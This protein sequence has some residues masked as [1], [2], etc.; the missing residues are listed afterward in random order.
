M[1]VRKIFKW[2]LP[3]CLVL[4]FFAMCPAQAAN[5]TDQIIAPVD[6]SLN[7]NPLKADEKAQIINVAQVEA[8]AA[9]HYCVGYCHKH[10]EERLIECSEP[11]H[12]HHHR[13][14]EW[15]RERERECLDDCYKHHPH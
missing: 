14:E 10:Y 8:Q 7:A 4:S 3:V 2:A 6:D 12:P 15:A 5:T 9:E 13:C 1:S 11:G